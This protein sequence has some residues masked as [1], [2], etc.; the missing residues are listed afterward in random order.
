MSFSFAVSTQKT[1]QSENSHTSDGEKAPFR[2]SS[3]LYRTDGRNVTTKQRLVRYVFICLD[4]HWDSLGL[5]S[6]QLMMKLAVRTRALS[7]SAREQSQQLE[8][9][10]GKRRILNDQ[11]ER[12]FPKACSQ[13]VDFLSPT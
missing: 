11:K 7:S 6:N 2:N 4:S 3:P 8:S 12:S 5:I 9:P 13:P 1:K 10:G